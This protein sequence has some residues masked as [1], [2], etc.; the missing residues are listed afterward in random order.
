VTEPP[1]VEARGLVKHF[2]LGA[3]VLRAVDGVSFTVARG[4]TL[5]LVGESGSGK[6]ATASSILRLLPDAGRIDGGK[7][8]YGG[9]DL[10]AMGPR[11][12]R[13]IRGKEIAMMF[14]DPH[15][16]LDPVI[17]AGEQVAEA[18]RAHGTSRLRA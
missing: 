7:A 11:E 17:P 5:A 15:A 1:L 13:R 10:L 4:E 2:P 18:A 9:R 14:Q 3:G 16:A 8:I 12:I 6:T